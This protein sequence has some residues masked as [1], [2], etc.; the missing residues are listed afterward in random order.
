VG[1]YVTTT[2]EEN[3]EE[4]KRLVE[5]ATYGFWGCLSVFVAVLIIAGITLIGWDVGWWFKTQNANR[6]AHLIRHGYSNQQT[7]RD[8]ITKNIGDVD[9]ITV[10]IAQTTGPL[11]GAL[12]A[13]R[14][15]VA[16]IVCHDADQVTGDPLPQDQASWVAANCA[17][18]VVSP[19][20]G[21]NQ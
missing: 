3:L 21:Y 16:G 15:A 5:K 2:E 18:G 17:N 11:H 7:L 14:F 19:S 10:Q 4:G 8:E 12:R 1:W 13:Q 9:Q 20:S 6:Q